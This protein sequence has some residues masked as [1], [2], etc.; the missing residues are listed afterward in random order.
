[1]GDVQRLD[2][3]K[4]GTFV[5]TIRDMKGLTQS[6]VCERCDIKPPY[7]WKLEENGVPPEP[8]IDRVQELAIGLGFSLPEFLQR[9]QIIQETVE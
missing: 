1:M 8:G 4:L 3:T 2:V 6:E 7:L 9:C 5:K